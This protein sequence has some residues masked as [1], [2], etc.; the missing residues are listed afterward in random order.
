MEIGF[1][2]PGFNKSIGGFIYKKTQFKS[3]RN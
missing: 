3:Y 1:A 2:N